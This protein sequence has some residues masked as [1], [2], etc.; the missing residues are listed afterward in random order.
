MQPEVT[1]T[2]SEVSLFKEIFTTLLKHKVFLC[3]YSPIYQIFT[4]ISYVLSMVSRHWDAGKK[5]QSSAKQTKGMH[6]SRREKSAKTT[7]GVWLKRK[8]L[9]REHQEPFPLFSLPALHLYLH[10]RPLDPTEHKPSLVLSW[11]HSPS[12]PRMH[13]AGAPLPFSRNISAHQPQITFPR[14]CGK[15]FTSPLWLPQKWGW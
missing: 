10:L 2:L 4:G 15:T 11:P 14:R 1:E 6:I 13:I 12:T 9:R 3:E 5:R 8:D 7:T